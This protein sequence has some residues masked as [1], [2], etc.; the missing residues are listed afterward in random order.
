MYIFFSTVQIF[1]SASLHIKKEK[2]K[3]E[4]RKTMWSQG[5]TEVQEK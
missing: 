5:N 4:K 1:L 2:V 3:K